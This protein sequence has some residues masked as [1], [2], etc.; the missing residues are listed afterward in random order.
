MREIS[1]LIARPDGS[2]IEGR[3]TFSGRIERIEPLATPSRDYLLPGL[4]DL[5][6]N[7]THG[8][9]VMAASVDDLTDISRY[10]AR[11]GVTRYLPTAITSSLETFARIDR[12]VSQCRKVNEDACDI[13]SIGGLHL[14]GPFISAQR[15]GVHPRLILEPAGES[16]ERVLALDQLRL[17]TIAPELPGAIEAI[18]R[19]NQRGVAVS[20]GHTDASLAQAQSA[21]GAGARMFTHVFN[22]MRPLHH[23]DPGVLTA[24]LTP[25]P[26]FA[27]VIADGVHVH[28]QVLAL[29]YRARGS[30][31]MILTSDKVG[32]NPGDATRFSSATNGKRAAQA[33]DGRLAGSLVPLLDGV[34]LM[35]AE[36]GASVGEAALMAATNPAHLLGMR[37]QGRVEVGCRAD[38]LVLDSQMNLKTV[39]IAGC[40]LE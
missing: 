27:A 28:P 33:A 15:L 17:L 24:A 34:R 29:I 36:V 37:E 20:I 2:V 31:G 8:M 30:S 11:E 16:L 26:A 10:L 32:A 9:D 3:V 4:I 14:E 1:G 22:A 5:Q 13:A 21:V 7:G 12:V 38:L 40:E 23:R 35:V 25:S 18:R 6:V 19:A 39:F